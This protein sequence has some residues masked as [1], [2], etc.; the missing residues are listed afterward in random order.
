[1]SSASIPAN[2]EPG[3]AG[4]RRWP[5]LDLGDERAISR[6]DWIVAAVTF[7]VVIVLRLRYAWALSVNSDEPQHLHVVWGWMTGRLQYKEIFDNHTPLFH[8]LMAPVLW[9][10]G[11]RA[12]IIVWMR[13]AMLPLFFG[14]LW[15]LYLMGKAFW[16]KRAGLYAAV[17]ASVVPYLFFK[18]GEFRTDVLWTFFWVASL[19]VLIGGDLT[20]RRCFYFGLLLGATISV[21]MKTILMVIA[22]ALS[23]I[24]VLVCSWFRSRKAPGW[25]VALLPAAALAGFLVIPAL[26]IS[27]FAWRH[28][29]PEMRYCV[30]DHNTTPGQSIF[31]RLHGHTRYLLIRTPPLILIAAAFWCGIYRTRGRRAGTD[32]LFPFLAFSVSASSG[33]GRSLHRRIFCHLNHWPFYVEHQSSFLSVRNWPRGFTTPAFSGS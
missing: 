30:I 1:M 21:S 5:R 15:M 7:V 25:R 8:M 22:V 18:L 24:I 11:E 32:F 19:A 16:S 4:N 13:L 23:A 31:S 12:D 27:Y 14:C 2:I 33:S 3:D 17:F 20:W 29:L 28:S 9:L 26:L 10:F 6:A